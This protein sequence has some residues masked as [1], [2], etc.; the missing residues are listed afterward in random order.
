MPIVRARYAAVGQGCLGGH[1]L[2]P[3]LHLS[4]ATA[5]EPAA[6]AAVSRPA[7]VRRPAPKAKRRAQVQAEEAPAPFE[8]NPIGENGRDG[9]GQAAP[10]A[11]K[12]QYTGLGSNASLP[13]NAITKLDTRG[14]NAPRSAPIFTHACSCLHA[15]RAPITERA[16]RPE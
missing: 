12:T 2:D 9:Y 11:I 7:P 13:A 15:H 10:V 14:W 4:R 8:G 1:G 5:P 3:P 6:A 16:L